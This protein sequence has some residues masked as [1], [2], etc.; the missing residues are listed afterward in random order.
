MPRRAE[1]LSQQ[2]QAELR[3]L[4]KILM[5]F[6]VA[7]VSLFLGVT[8]VV[9]VKG[10]QALFLAPLYSVYLLI[11][12]VYILTIFFA[13]IFNDVKNVQRFAMVQVG[14][15]LSI[16]TIIVYLSGGYESP[17]P[18]LYLLSILWASLAIPAGG[19]WTASISA[20]TYG[21]VVDLMYYRILKP[22]LTAG[23]VP[24][25]GENPFDV[26][27]RMALHI[28]AF[29]AVAFLG[30]QMARRY[31]STTEALTERTA[32]LEKLRQLSDM[33]FES[34]NSGIA[35]LDSSGR[36]GSMNS[37]GLQILGLNEEDL[38]L[39]GLD[40]VF[41]GIPI[42]ELCEKS[43]GGYLNRWEGTF[44]DEDGR[45]RTLGLSISRLKEPEKGFVVVYQDLS[46]FRS[47]EDKVRKSEQLT[48]LGRMAASIAHEVRNPLASMSGSIQI[49]QSTLDLKG[50][51]RKL[52]DIV[53]TET[54]R[55]NHLVEGFLSYA[56]PPDPRFEDVDLREVI[57]ETVDFLKSSIRSEDI[58]L[59]TELPEE[60]VILSLDVSQIRQIIINLVKNSID[61]VD[62][63]GKISICLERGENK[64]GSVTLL[65]VTD[66]GSG[67]PE[68]VLPEVF[69]P[70]MTT[71]E[72]GS[73]LGL[74][75]VYQLLQAH[76]ASIDVSSVE[77]AGTTFTISL[78]E[79]R[80]R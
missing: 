2:T 39:G 36:V 33:V 26:M 68:K 42:G 43:I 66:D 24:A 38:R 80:S 46:D 34:I 75:I 17:F 48:A 23:F 54:R 1:Q 52:M 55:L 72:G 40:D 13:S 30:H 63:S 74:A 18:F 35:V 10:T 45:A 25:A 65:S 21:G 29:Y 32:D 15:D 79:W 8:V 14:V 49:L 37:A 44:R 73:G 62:G 69:E 57:S 47:L 22:P 53:L 50:E 67:I 77:D 20:I 3:K 19:Y 31:R 64:G 59:R 16:S 11:V 28:T 71:R 78:P 60:P 27:G 5:V 41:K 58:D 4:L 76:Q 7:T 51:D 56:R 12:S 70:F 6:R 61:A 9:Q